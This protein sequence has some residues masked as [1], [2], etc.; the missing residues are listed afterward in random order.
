MTRR[1][2]Q[3]QLRWQRRANLIKAGI[4][5]Y[6]ARTNRTTT[7]ADLLSNWRDN[8][9]V[10]IAGRIRSFRLQGGSAF[11]HLADETAK[12]QVFF[13]KKNLSA[14]T[15]LTGQIDLGDFL[16]VTGTTFVTKRGEKTVDATTVVW[17]AKALRP[18]P[19]EWH[20]LEDVELRYRYREL[21]LLSHQDVKRTFID[22]ARIFSAVHEFLRQRGFL[23]VETPV[24]QPIPGG[25]S[26]KPF[27]T[28]HHAV[29]ADMYLRVAPE[30]YLKRLIVA[31]LGR[32]YEI[33]RNF[34]NEGMDRDHN[35]EFSEMEC[36]AAFTDYRWMMKLVE[37]LIIHVT[38]V[39]HG[40]A[41]I[42][43]PNK[44]I[45]LQ[46]PFARMTY[47]QAVREETGIDVDTIDDKKLRSA[48]TKMK[49]DLKGKDNRAQMIDEIFK[50]HVRP[51][52]IQPIFI[53]DYPIEL[54]PLAKKIFSNPQYTE[55][56]Q[57]FI[58]G[59]ELCN[60]FSELNDP[61]DQRQRFEA[62]ENM[63]AKGDDEAQRIDETFLRSL[64]YGMPPTSGLGVGI[65]RLVAVILGK[66]T[67]KEVI[68]FPTMKP[69]SP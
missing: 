43:W 10:T 13:Q 23:E 61:V 62:Q 24:L 7:A 59:T 9:T 1:S 65:D 27:I 21:D 45:R 68:L 67:I 58:A 12:L 39:I 64:E 34:R 28:H 33:G 42:P 60:A 17:L 2:D 63:R 31:G 40:Q 19:S 32:V 50:T 18:L 38:T 56:F 48:A 29:D 4:D 54:S 36:Y 49:T 25:A 55:R 51:K 16:E 11:L 66:K 6:P 8:Q 57:L 41:E 26:A 53:H 3:E 52:M 5:V 14:F 44:K 47:R 37:D 35:P 20:G 15:D 22:R 69:E 46:K 30:L